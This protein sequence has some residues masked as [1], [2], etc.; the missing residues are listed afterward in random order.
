LSLL[1][2]KQYF[3]ETGVIREKMVLMDIALF[4][5]AVWAGTFSVLLY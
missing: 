2:S 5:L 1:L 3:K 4:K